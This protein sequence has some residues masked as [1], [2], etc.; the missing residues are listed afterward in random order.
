M[1]LKIKW[2]YQA[3]LQ[4]KGI[5]NYIRV[6]SLSNARKVR[7]EIVSTALQTCKYPEKNPLDKDKEDN[8]GSYRCF[9]LHN[10]RISYKIDLDKISVLRIR[11]TSMDSLKY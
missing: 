8:D 6:D 1:T 5:Y 7:A 4:L 2:S 11:H 10:Y 3:I 9:V